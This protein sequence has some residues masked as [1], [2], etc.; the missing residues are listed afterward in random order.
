VTESKKLESREQ[1]L[2]WILEQVETFNIPLETFADVRPTPK[3]PKIAFRNA[4]GESW[5]GQGELPE[6]LRRAVNAGQSMDHFN[7]G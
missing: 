7:V 2:D 1:V 5:D 3:P 6:W 4:N